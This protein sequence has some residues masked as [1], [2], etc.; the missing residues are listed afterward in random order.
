MGYNPG[1]V[2]FQYDFL[3]DGVENG[4]IVLDDKMPAGLREAIKDGKEIIIFMNPP[5]GAA[6]EFGEN[7]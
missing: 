6:G 3:N 1:S 4:E 7:F 5:Y 2:K